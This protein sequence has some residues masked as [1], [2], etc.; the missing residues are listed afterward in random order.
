MSGPHWTDYIAEAEDR[1]VPIAESGERF[2]PRS[3]EEAE[4]LLAS[5]PA[6]ST[7]SDGAPMDGVVSVVHERRL[8]SEWI[9]VTP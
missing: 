7:Y 9:E 5:M 1:W 2:A 3:K 6:G 4:A 8:V